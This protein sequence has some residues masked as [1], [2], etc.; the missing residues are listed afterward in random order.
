MPGAAEAAT[1]AGP[2][3]P[4]PCRSPPAL[5]RSR[6][7]LLGS[8]QAQPC[9]QATELFP[10]AF[11]VQ[12]ATFEM[13]RR[14]NRPEKYDRELVHKTGGCRVGVETGT[15]VGAGPGR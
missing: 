3:S 13:E 11:S 8:M 5:Q 15:L 9:L 1:N 10:R 7:A 12:D 4:L 6:E 14:R 2:S